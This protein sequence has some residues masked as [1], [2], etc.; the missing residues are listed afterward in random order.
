M[1]AS[2]VSVGC[3]C[4]ELGGGCLCSLCW[5]AH[6]GGHDLNELRHLAALFFP[7]YRAPVEEGKVQPM[8]LG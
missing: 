8:P 6:R 7:L 2:V 1:R 4:V 3:E 5:V